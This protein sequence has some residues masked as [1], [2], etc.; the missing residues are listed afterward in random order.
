M[1]SGSRGLAGSVEPGQAGVSVKISPYASHRV[2][3]CRADGDQFRSDVHVILHAGFVYARKAS[4]HM[5]FVE[6][7]E[8]EIHN[9]IFG[10]APF[11]F[12]HDGA[13]H[14]IA[15]REFRHR[16]VLCHKAQHLQIAQVCALAAQGLRKQK[17]RRFF[18]IQSRRMELN[19][20]KISHLSSSPISHCHSVAGRNAW[21]SRIQIQ[22]SHSASRKQH[23]GGMDCV[24]LAA[25]VYYTNAANT[26]V[27]ADQIS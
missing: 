19:E 1:N 3:C 20:F 15:R 13:C 25:I 4:L 12:V 6:M 9:R 26:P 22:L 27:L 8:I 5:G 24:F 23:R 11:E 16:V 7:R 21:V 2:V 14:H 18:Q 10:A 17:S